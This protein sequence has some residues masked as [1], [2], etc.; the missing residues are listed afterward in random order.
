LR[1]TASSG[2]TRPRVSIVAGKENREAT[3]ID[4]RWQTAFALL[5]TLL[6]SALAL[7]VVL[8]PKQLV[9]IDLGSRANQ[10]STADL[11]KLISDTRTTMLQAIAG[12]AVLLG[13]VFTYRQLSV[14]REGQITERFTRAVEQ[15]G[16]DKTDVRV[17]ALY[18]LERIAFDSARD[19]QAITDIVAAFVRGRAPW[20]PRDGSTHDH[21]GDL[22]SL[23]T[24]GRRA[25]DVEAA[26]II[27]GR[28]P[29]RRNAR[30][31]H[32][33]VLGNCDLR[34]TLLRH[35]DLSEVIFRNAHLERTTLRGANLQRASL[36]GANL[37][38]TVLADAKLQGA[39]FTDAVSDS[40]TVWPSGFDAA[41][42]GVKIIKP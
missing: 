38:G 42:A 16:N 29:R 28:R 40:T 34:N 39:D 12:L 10:L 35:A 24:M 32:P 36:V 23:P 11:G 20:P 19:S 15:L 18:A 25:P 22:A 3:T 27:L 9:L 2:R 5:L 8:A 1:A 6:T 31:V 7:L 17:G 14:T 30:P 26:L 33:L 37:R 13:A 4:R 21:Q 41:A